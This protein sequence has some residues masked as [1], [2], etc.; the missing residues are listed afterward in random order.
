MNGVRSG[1]TRCGIGVLQNVDSLLSLLAVL[2][3]LNGLGV[4][5]AR[6]RSSRRAYTLLGLFE[7]N[8]LLRD[9][10]L[11][12]GVSLLSSTGDLKRGGSSSIS[13]ITGGF[14]G[15]HSRD[16]VVVGD[17]LIVL[18]NDLFELVL[19]LVVLLV[20]LLLILQRLLVILRKTGQLV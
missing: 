8:L 15:T 11:Q 14:G 3:V 4:S 13:V 7:G 6:V 5:A 12:L 2:S 20:S 18:A 16:L 19:H 17:S 9:L 1:G 10:V